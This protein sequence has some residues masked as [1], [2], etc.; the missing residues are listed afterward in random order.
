MRIVDL[1][2][3]APDA[4]FDRPVFIELEPGKRQAVRNAEEAIYALDAKGWSPHGPKHLA[5]RAANIHALLGLRE[6]AMARRA[7]QEAACES[8]VLADAEAP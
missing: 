1:N 7:F 2:F 5:A 8:D 3:S 6:A 4:T